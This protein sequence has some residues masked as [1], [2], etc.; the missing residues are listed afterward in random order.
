MFLSQ[1]KT[2]TLIWNDGIYILHRGS[3]MDQASEYLLL[4]P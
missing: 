2:Q 4:K 1:N 3:T